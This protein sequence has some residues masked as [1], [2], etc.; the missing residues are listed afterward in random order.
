MRRKRAFDLACALGT[1]LLWMPLLIVLMLMVRVFDGPPIFY[2]QYRLGYRGRRFLTY[3]LRTF[4]VG[5]D[6]NE[7]SN[8]SRPEDDRATKLGT[9]LRYSGFDELP[10]LLNVLK[11]DMSIVGP[12][13]WASRPQVIAELMEECPGFKKRLEVMPGLVTMTYLRHDPYVRPRHVL[14]YDMLYIRNMSLALDLYIL[15]IAS[16]VVFKRTMLL[17][18]RKVMRTIRAHHHRNP[19][20]E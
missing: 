12:R 10:Q 1:A 4:P 18:F 2:C 7:K 20:T 3:K 13:P 9:F 6:R 17:I 11:G 14:L 5:S 19:R 8:W 16:R 15:A